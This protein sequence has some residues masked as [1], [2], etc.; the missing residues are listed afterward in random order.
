MNND[1]RDYELT[2]HGILG[3]MFSELGHYFKNIGSQKATINVPKTA[4]IDDIKKY[5]SDQIIKQCNGGDFGAC[6]LFEI[7]TEDTGHFLAW[8]NVDGVINFVDP[9]RHSAS[10]DSYFSGIIKGAIESSIEAAR[11]DNL[12]IRVNNLSEI[13][14]NRR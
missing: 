6:G 2:H 10:A 12:E 9:Q 13:V 8:E 7:R 14:Q 5:V 4:N 11:F 1:W 3:L